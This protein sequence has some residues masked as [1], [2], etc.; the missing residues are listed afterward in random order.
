[1]IAA[2]GEVA[3][4]ADPPERHRADHPGQRAVGGL[5]HGPPGVAH[6][7][8]EV[9]RPRVGRPAHDRPELPDMPEVHIAHGPYADAGSIQRIVDERLES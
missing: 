9:E 2:D 1:V 8:Q 7:A 5:G 3:Q 6:P 4:D